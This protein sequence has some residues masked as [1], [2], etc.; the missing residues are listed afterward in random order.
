MNIK[1][2]KKNIEVP[3]GCTIE[4]LLNHLKSSK[5]VAIFVNNNQLLM[6]EY[7]NYRLNENDEVKIIKPL[8]GG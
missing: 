5:S 1:V 6:A 7:N 8:G 2:N 3:E 4:G